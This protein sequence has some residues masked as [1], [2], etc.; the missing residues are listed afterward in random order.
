[1]PSTFTEAVIENDPTVLEQTV[2][3]E[4]EAAFEG[5]EPAEGNLEVWIIKAFARIAS[6]VR[7]QAASTSVALFKR[8]GEAIVNV[9]PI[10]AAPATVESLWTMVD[11]AGY[12]IPVGTQVAI[13]ASGDLSLGFITAKEITV[14]PGSTTASVPLEAVESGAE[15]NGLTADPSL[16][17]AL[18]FVESIELEG[19]TA[20]GVDEEDEDD[21]LDRLVE[22]L[23]LLSLSPIADRD[24]EIDARSVPG[25]ARAKCIEAYNADEEKE[26]ALCVS[27]YPVDEDGAKLSS[28][29]KEELQK[30]QEAKVPSGVNVF[31]D[32]P[33]YTKLDVTA[34]V[35]V[36]TGFD[37]TTV[38]A[39]V[40]SRLAEYFDPAKWG[41]P[42]QGDA[43]T[44]SGWENRTTVY[45]F[46][47]ISELYRV[48][49]VDRVKSL[50]L[51]KHGSAL[52]TADVAL[53]GVVP[54][55][56][57]GDIEITAE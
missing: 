50:E 53:T 57:A 16:I 19:T 22:D 43:S 40:E 33:T 24:F 54:L 28:G 44:S 3:E 37:K 49:G 52:G 55:T 18:A 12:T 23:Q 42:S 29:V 27:V 15:G 26:E 41:V 1:M 39:A 34:A 2:I 47:L 10:Q 32:D 25:I 20:N 21:Y 13:A 46:E 56:E 11:N 31:V 38:I 9:P 36:K 5:W 6:T 17:D 7:E 8:F 51:A 4:L 30:R 35:V 48:G 45:R 14:A